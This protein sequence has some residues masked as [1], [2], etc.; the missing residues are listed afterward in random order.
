MIREPCRDVLLL[1]LLFYTMRTIFKWGFAVFSD[2]FQHF[3]L[4]VKKNMKKYG[5][6]KP[7]EY[8]LQKVTSPVVLYYS[9]N[10]RVID[11]GVS[12]SYLY[13][14][15]YCHMLLFIII[16]RIFFYIVN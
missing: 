2:K 10:D 15:F 16:I 7:P 4:G 1:L 8:N 5:Q 12:P 14:L 11:K 13:C 9:K 3:D 6:P